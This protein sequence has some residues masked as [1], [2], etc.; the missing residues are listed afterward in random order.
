[1]TARDT[2]R[3]GPHTNG[4]TDA[5]GPWALITGASSG[6]GLDIAREAARRGLDVVLVARRQ[7]RLE[8]LAA[9]LRDEH[10]VRTRVISADL[11]DAS[12]VTGVIRSAEDLDIGSLVANAGYATTGPF[13]QADIEAELDMLRVNAEAVLRLTHA[14]GR[15]FVER[16]RGGIVLLSSIVAFQGVPGTAHYAATKAYVQ[17]LA[18]GLHAELAPHGVDV[19]AS[20]P[21]PVKSGFAERADMR[22]GQAVDTGTVARETL[23]ALGRRR[24]VRP[25]RLSKVLGGGLSLAPR[26]LRTRILGRVIAGFTEHQ[27][28]DEGATEGA[29]AR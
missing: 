8:E 16:G 14:F 20:A 24:L 3:T 29:A 22:V 19:L 12:A 15:R 18:E 28:G 5:Y 6:I 4:F 17:S 21:G 10:G 26:G 25:G 2:Q 9:E 7:E 13:T 23:D 11:A 1:M 27:R